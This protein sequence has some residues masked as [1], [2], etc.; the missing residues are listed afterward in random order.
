MIT[1][2]IVIQQKQIQAKLTRKRRERQRVVQKGRLVQKRGVVQ[3]GRLV[4]KRGVVQ[5]RGS[6]EKDFSIYFHKL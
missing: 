2:F 5:K 3:K 4:Q 1:S 6:P